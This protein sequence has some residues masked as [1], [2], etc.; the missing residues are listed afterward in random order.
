MWIRIW[1][2]VWIFWKLVV[3]E[4]LIR[5]LDLARLLGHDGHLVGVVAP[6]QSS[7][8]CTHHGLHRAHLEKN[9]FVANG[10][11][12][13]SYVNK[14]NFKDTHAHIPGH[15]PRPLFV[16]YLLRIGRRKAE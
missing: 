14:V 12:N 8:H 3:K 4:R 6:G 9:K 2:R 15:T 11:E 7:N 10:R 1:I 13:H 5:Y 16:M